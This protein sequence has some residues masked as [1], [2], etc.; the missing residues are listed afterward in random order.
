M[1]AAGLLLISTKNV[2]WWQIMEYI[3]KELQR[4]L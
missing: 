1:V 2:V 4:E 3:V